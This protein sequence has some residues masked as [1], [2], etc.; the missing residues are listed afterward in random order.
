MNADSFADQIRILGGLQDSPATDRVL[1]AFRAVPREAFAGKGPWT[2]RS[3][4]EGFTLPVQQTPDANPK[5]LYNSVLIV[6][7][8]EKGI[9]I[10]DPVF[11]ARRLVRANVQPGTRV[12]QVGAV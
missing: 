6:L 8:Q 4:H 12:L 11:W 7:D 9:N 1:D 5:W 2:F 10:G 3:P